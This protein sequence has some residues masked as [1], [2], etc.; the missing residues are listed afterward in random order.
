MR[1]LIAA[2]L[3]LLSVSA[4]PARADTSSWSGTWDTRW[5]EGGARMILEQR[6][7]KVTGAYPA[8]GGRIEGDVKGRALTGHWTEGPRTG[9][10]LFVLAPDGQSFMG[11]FET[12]EWWTGGRVPGA[13]ATAAPPDHGSPRRALRS[14][15]AAGNRVAA[16]APDEMAK[17][18]EIVDFG[19]AG[20]TLA[21]GQKLEAAQDLFDLIN[22]TTFHLFAV[23]GLRYQQDRMDLTLQQAGSDAALPITLIRGAD[24]LWRIQMPSADAIEAARKALLARTGGRF[25]P[26]GDYLLRRNARDAMRAFLAAFDDWDGAGRAQA[27]EALDL[28]D[29]SDAT[30]DYEGGL[31]AQYLNEVLKRIGPI[32]PQEI[33]NDPASRE[34]FLV[35]SHPAGRIVLAPAGEGDAARWRFSAETVRGARDLYAAIEDMPVADQ[36]PAPPPSRF[37]QVR[38]AIRDNIP[39]LLRRV[40]QVELWQVLGVVLILAAAFAAS[41][42]LAWPLLALL[43]RAVG[44]Q[45]RTAEY[46]FR[47]PLRLA[48]TF[49]LYK[50]LV[51]V[52]GLPEAAGRVSIGASGVLL[53]AS[54]MWGGWKLIDALG[55]N[56]LERAERRQGTMDSILVSLAMGALKVVLLAGGFLYV[57][58]VLSIPYD[59]VLAGLG[60]GGLAVAFASKETLSNV[61]GAGIL[62]AD[63][64]FRRGDW[65]VAGDTQGTVE[66]VG[67]RSTRIRTAEDSVI[68]VPNGK[69]ADATINNLGTRRRRLAKLK[70]L[71]PYDAAPATLDAFMAE[72]AQAA[73]AVPEVQQERTQV[74]VSALGP[75]GIEVELTT[76]LNVRSAVEE[77][78]A[79]NRL[80]LDV[81][82]LAE[83]MG[84]RLGD[85]PPSAEPPHPAQVA[86]A[87]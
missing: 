65:I 17:A 11:R 22:L 73:N 55:V 66:H 63:R 12:G 29:L 64:P 14:F 34:P 33:P 61:F 84:I 20:A 47:W 5:R 70:L 45:E 78:A 82:R 72:L 24:G 77:R 8:Y 49:S 18:A 79:K 41:F 44:G 4:M 76:Y 30:R 50:L 59:G 71:L 35:F 80:A 23:P 51:P 52:L 48:L 27:L 58:S 6:G 40:G 26:S 69:L 7:D 15:V 13:A 10:L 38:Q 36:A 87:A 85:Q 37:F 68:V 31:A 25:P 21:P 53:A 46:E 42:V 81:L 3:A 54:A 39:A 1:L 16:S 86:Q 43:R 83:R 60:I 74:G 9:G 62:V 28:S 57:A 75:E 19:E 56:A 2:L 32:I 67:I